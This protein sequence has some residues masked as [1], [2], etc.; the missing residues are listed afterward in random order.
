MF[1]VVM[2]PKRLRTSSVPFTSDTCTEPLLS[3]TETFPPAPFSSMLPKELFSR[4]A[5]RSRTISEPWLFSMS[6]A[7]WMPVA[8]T[9]P[10]LLRTGQRGVGRH[11]NVVTH[12]PGGNLDFAARFAVELDLT[13][14]V[15]DAHGLAGP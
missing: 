1:R 9:P 2:L 8:S 10:K 7:A 3:F 4:A 6:V 5:P 13:E 14:F 11:A 12:G 15:L